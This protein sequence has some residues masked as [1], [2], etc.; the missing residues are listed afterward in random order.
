[1]HPRAQRKCCHCKTFFVPDPRNRHHQRY[2]GLP[3]C[4]QASKAASQKRWEGRPEN[5]DYYRGPEKVAK[6]RA[7]RRR[8]PVTGGG[9][10][11]RP[12]RYQMY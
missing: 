9:S 11:Q 5:R 4:R 8:T 6:V 7:W 1:M 2:C 3:A 10:G 12:M